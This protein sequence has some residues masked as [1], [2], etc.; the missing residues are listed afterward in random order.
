MARA[1]SWSR[2]TNFRSFRFRSISRAARTSS[3]TKE[4]VSSFVG[5][6]MREGTATRTA[7]Q[8]NNELA[9]LGTNVGFGVGAES[10]TAGFSSLARTFDQTVD[11][12]MD[13]ML[14]SSFPA[15]ALER[16]RTQSL[17]AYTRSQDVVGTIACAD[18][19]QAALRRP[20][21]RQGRER[22]RPEG[23]DARRRGEPREGAL[24]PGQ[25]DRVRRRRH[26]AGHGEG[27][28]SS[29]RSRS[30]RRAARSWRSAIR[31]LR[32][33]GRPRFIWWTCP[34]SRSRRS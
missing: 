15:P 13:M 19:A 28:R 7:D 11:I 6:M 2:S 26:D 12:M 21:V 24:R 18:H 34:T 22:C 29:A 3:A 32:R 27:R 4:G 1:W 30:G 17:A 9:L 5:A 31:L 8:L 10:G 33:P 14:H 23:G 20:A 16:L 25:R